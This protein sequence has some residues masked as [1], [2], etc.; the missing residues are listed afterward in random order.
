MLQVHG[1]LNCPGV[2]LPHGAHGDMDFCV[3]TILES[4]IT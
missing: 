3:S 2:V 1:S 4:R